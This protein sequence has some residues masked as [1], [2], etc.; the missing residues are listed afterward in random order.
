MLI[1]VVF[2]Q[3]YMLIL[4]PKYPKYNGLK[5]PVDQLLWMISLRCF[6]NLGLCLLHF[7]LIYVM[8]VMNRDV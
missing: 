7:Q 1:K 2:L 6:S 8:Y 3:I 5:Y 4:I